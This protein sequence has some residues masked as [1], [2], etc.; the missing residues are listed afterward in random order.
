[1][2]RKF[3]VFLNAISLQ[4]WVEPVGHAPSNLSVFLNIPVPKRAGD[5]QMTTESDTERDRCCLP[6]PGV[7]SRGQRREE[8]C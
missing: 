7:H 4:Q 2:F 8:S 3:E 5:L 6:H 1:M